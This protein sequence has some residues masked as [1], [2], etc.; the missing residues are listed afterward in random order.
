MDEHVFAAI[1]LGDEAVALVVAEP[2]HGSGCHISTSP[3]RVSRRSG[4]H[5]RTAPAPPAQSP[6]AAR[7][8]EPVR[9]PPRRRSGA[10]APAQRSHSPPRRRAA[11]VRS[12][13]APGPGCDEQLLDHDRPALLAAQGGVSRRST[14]L[15]S[16]EDHIVL[17][18]LREHLPALGLAMITKRTRVSGEPEAAHSV[19]E[20][21]FSSPR[22]R[23]LRSERLPCRRVRSSC[24][25][26]T[27][28]R[29]DARLVCPATGARGRAVR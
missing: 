17:E 26:V 19:R 16:D 25:D 29:D 8:C 20:R 13:T 10:R 27:L 18:H 5:V 14:L 3:D 21:S 1:V 24:L 22:S 28:Q 7:S 23:T 6:N 9:C 15:A 11:G 12:R 2:L 4:A